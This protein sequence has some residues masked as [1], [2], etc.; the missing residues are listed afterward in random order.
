MSNF[1]PHPNY[2]INPLNPRKARLNSDALINRI[3]VPLK[4]SGIFYKK[5]LTNFGQVVILLMSI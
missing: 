1:Q 2:L 5:L 4:L 3:G